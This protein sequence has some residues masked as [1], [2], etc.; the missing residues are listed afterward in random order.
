[1]PASDAVSFVT[2][3]HDRPEYGSIDLKVAV[4]GAD[5]APLI[6]CVHGWPESWHSWRHQMTHFA[7]RG[8][9]VAAMNVR[10]YPGSSAPEPVSAYRITE[11]AADAAVVISQLSPNAP[12][13]LVGHDWGAP[14][15]WHTTRLHPP[16]VRAVAGMS[17]PYLPATEGDPMELWDVVYAGRFFYMKYFQPAGVPEAAFGADIG[18]ALR[19]VWFAASA[20]STDLWK[21]DWPEDHAMLDGMVDPDPAPDWMSPEKIAP[22]IAAFDDAPLHGLFNRYRAQGLDAQELPFLGDPM[23][24]QPSCFIGGA[25]DI[26][27]DFVPGVDIFQ[28]AGEACDD[29]R[30][31]TIID[32]AGHWVQQEAPEETNAA[33]E[34]FLNSL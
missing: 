3:T 21:A 32:G 5:D 15:V 12:A 16:Q 22:V 7:E 9:R 26:V 8:W 29:F 2:I 30:G 23:I 17:V 34:A 19:K 33:L 13:V 4:A 6:L 31:L 25:Q 10:G 18:T 14:I 24:A 20:S 27:R 11:L 28:V 1:M